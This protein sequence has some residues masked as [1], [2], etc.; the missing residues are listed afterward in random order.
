[1]ENKVNKREESF[2]F[3]IPIKYKET[4]AKNTYSVSLKERN[5]VYSA[6]NLK[7]GELERNAKVLIDAK[8]ILPPLNEDKSTSILPEE[9]QT[10]ILRID[11]LNSYIQ[12]FYKLN[13]Q[14]KETG[15]E[16]LKIKLLSAYKEANTIN[17]EY[18][19]Y[20][21]KT[22]N[23]LKISNFNLTNLQVVR[24]SEANRID[25]LLSQINSLTEAN[26]KL[27]QSNEMLEMKNEALQAQLQSTESNLTTKF[28]KVLSEHSNIVNLMNIDR[29]TQESG[30]LDKMAE[31]N[32]KIQC[33]E[34]IETSN[35]KELSL[36][37]ETNIKLE[38]E[39]KKITLNNDMQAGIQND[40]IANFENQNQ[41]LQNI[42]EALE[43]EILLLSKNNTYLQ[44]QLEHEHRNSAIFK[45]ESQNE[46]EK[47][48][49]MHQAFK[50]Q[51]ESEKS[52][53]I[54]MTNE[55]RLLR[56][57]FA[58]LTTNTNQALKDSKQREDGL[59]NAI[60]GLKLKSQDDNKS[61]FSERQHQATKLDEK[62]NSIYKLLTL[63]AQS[64]K[65]TIKSEN[66]FNE[67]ILMFV[68]LKGRFE[69][70][71][72]T[73]FELTKTA[74]LHSRDSNVTRKLVALMKSDINSMK[75][76]IS[77]LTNT[78]KTVNI[79]NSNLKSE[80]VN[81]KATLDCQ[82]NSANNNY[83]LAKLF[84]AQQ[85]QQQHLLS[86]SLDAYKTQLA[87]S[88]FSNDS[89]QHSILQLELNITAL[90]TNISSLQSKLKET[91]L[92]LD[93]A[94]NNLF[95][96]NQALC[97]LKKS[98]IIFDSHLNNN[99]HQYQQHQASRIALLQDTINMSKEIIKIVKS[100]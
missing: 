51:S 24:V 10:M 82:I 39:N 27:S 69:Q 21:D 81:A 55:T 71:E 67:A 77:T 50:R 93:H 62:K 40:K 87:N 92:H 35:N 37:K 13:G 11:R 45:T 33:L 97:D 85:F 42:N 96:K 8:L 43:S 58:E 20:K 3:S 86:S 73:I 30:N 91:L 14:S 32:T 2:A 25:F 53:F 23:E 46:F 68:V 59:G 56:R 70:T 65:D 88:Q 12:H 34:A 19:E 17:D 29:Q 47:L 16:Q 83:S 90:N 18:N 41:N 38:F 95:I 57:Q 9:W 64:R 48:S 79:E 5:L 61:Y 22:E 36:L 100:K 94:N 78:L 4:S 63:L 52:Q 28:N 1:M 98:H 6:V 49:A 44:M 7:I 26:D 66:K 31:M 80:F 74:K 75:E 60:V 54:N 99:I 76:T 15:V 84:I 72:E 89:K